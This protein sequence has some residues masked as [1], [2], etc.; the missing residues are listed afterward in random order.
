M[1]TLVLEDTMWIFCKGFSNHDIKRDKVREAKNCE[2]VLNSI[3]TGQVRTR[4]KLTSKILPVNEE[5]LAYE[6][7][8]KIKS[9]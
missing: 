5:G 8:Q 2:F 4:F 6:P 7:T 9:A 3:L 1:I